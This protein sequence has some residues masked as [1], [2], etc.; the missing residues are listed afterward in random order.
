MDF[1]RKT[2]NTTAVSVKKIVKQFSLVFCI[3][4]VPA[5]GLVA[6][7]KL[8]QCISMASQMNSQLPRQIDSITKLEA[9]S[10]IEDR[11]Q[12]FFQYV[13]I[14]S[15]SSKLPK[16]VEKSAKL[17][18]KNQYCTN[19]EFRNALSIFNFDFYY[20]DTRKNPLYSF[21]LTKNDC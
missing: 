20:L 2:M 18:A 7:T 1:V 8:A 4:I 10:C 15:S 17:S 6:Q 12:I 19:K 16:D 13:H 21:T 11:G 9:T 5:H 14:I 3:S